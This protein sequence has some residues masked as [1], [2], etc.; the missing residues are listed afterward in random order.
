MHQHA[1][2]ADAVGVVAVDF[3][4]VDGGG[5]RGEVERGD[6][7]GAGEGVDPFARLKLASGDE[8]LP[9]G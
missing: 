4:I 7:A 1:Q 8:R 2:R 6:L 3:E 9:R 5:A